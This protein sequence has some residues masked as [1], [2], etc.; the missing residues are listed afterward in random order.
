V[1]SYAIIKVEVFIPKRLAPLKLHKKKEVVGREEE[2]FQ[3]LETTQNLVSTA[4]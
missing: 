4:R 2:K 1:A 3:T